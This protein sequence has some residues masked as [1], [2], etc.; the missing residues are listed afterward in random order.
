LNCREPK[1]RPSANED[2][3]EAV[4]WHVRHK[5]YSKASRLWAEWQA[6]LAAIELMPRL[7]PPAEDAPPG[8]EIRNYLTRRYGYRIVFEITPTELVVLAFV[9]GHRQP[10]SWLDRLTPDRGPT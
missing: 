3:G 8:R 9:N 2:V 10:R 7:H 1:V 4:A 6:G 5:R